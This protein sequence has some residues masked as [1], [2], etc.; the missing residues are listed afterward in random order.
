MILRDLLY[1]VCR[2]TRNTPSLKH[3]HWEDLLLW[4]RYIDVVDYD[5]KQGVGEQRKGWDVLEMALKSS[6]FGRAYRI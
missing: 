4:K 5:R 6:P 2:S 3:Q 1:L